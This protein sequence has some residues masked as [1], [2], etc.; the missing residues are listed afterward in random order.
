MTAST[1]DP[2]LADPMLRVLRER[3]PD[4]DVVLLPR[5]V[6]PPGSPTMDAAQ[7]AALSAAADA[8]VGDVLARLAREGAWTGAERG[9]RW[10]TDEWGLVHY[11]SVASVA[12]LGE[13]GNISLLR[14]TGAALVDLGWQAR[15]VS[16]DPPGLAAR[17]GP[18]AAAATV[19]PTEL[20]LTLRTARVRR[21][22][23]PF[24]GSGDPR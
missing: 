3:H 23:D 17:R 12:D 9:G 5:P 15:P 7:L 2:A 21:A 11:E 24:G 4:V 14:A 19:R 20:V 10:R 6:P 22:S 8:A 18:L 13:G 16:G 1:P